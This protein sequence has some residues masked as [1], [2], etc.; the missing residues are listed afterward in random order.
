MRMPQS[1]WTDASSKSSISWVN[2]SYP[3][4]TL[5]HEISTTTFQLD[6]QAAMM[7]IAAESGQMSE[8]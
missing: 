8:V 6:V 2:I 7:G 1:C 5:P 3:F 4:K